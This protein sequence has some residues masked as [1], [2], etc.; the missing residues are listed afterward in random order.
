MIQRIGVVVTNFCR[1]S[2]VVEDDLQLII[3]T[4]YA[5]IIQVILTD[6]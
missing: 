3:E 4:I 2:G 6:H 5:E 1:I